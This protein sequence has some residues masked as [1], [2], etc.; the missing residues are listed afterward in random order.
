[1]PSLQRA[2]TLPLTGL[3][4]GTLAGTLACKTEE[5]GISSDEA[6][7]TIAEAAC[8][9]YY[10]CECEADP[11]LYSS[12]ADCRLEVAGQIQEG[13]D[14][15]IEMELIYDDSCPGAWLNVLEA[16]GCDY[17]LQ[18]FLNSD[19]L[20]LGQA[21]DA[22]KL[23]RGDRT[24]GQSCTRRAGGVGDDCDEESECDHQ[25][26]CV[27]YDF[28]NPEG[29]DCA[30]G[31]DD[32]LPGLVCVDI[33]GGQDRIC[34]D[35][36]GQGQTCMGSADLCDFDLYCDQESK[37]CVQMPGSG[38][39]CA[40]FEGLT[41]T[42]D[43]ESICEGDTCVDLPTGGQA[44]AQG[45]RCAVGFRCEGQNEGVCVEDVPYV[46]NPYFWT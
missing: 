31:Q 45:R 16:V 12:E 41:G 13:I 3:V 4:A 43:L 14:Q 37:N 18:V 25:D 6:A 34:E 30:P 8:R 10:E 44:C 15:A 29:A 9:L 26:Q 39:P 35:L 38:E 46:C 24:D 32:C 1:M 40:P 28:G 27:E 2:L 21:A 11:P 23:Y 20:N 7:E 33:N 36:P 22:C 17:T 42:C 19:L 5:G